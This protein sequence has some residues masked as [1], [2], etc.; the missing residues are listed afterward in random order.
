MIS[1]YFI[2][3]L[4]E[5]PTY[6]SRTWFQQDEATFHTAN[7]TMDEIHEQFPQKCIFR[8]GDITWPPRSPDLILI[9]FFVV[10]LKS[11]VY[12][13]Y[14]RISA[15]SREKTRREVRVIEPAMLSSGMMQNTMDR[16]PE[17][18]VRNGRHLKDVI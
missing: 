12:L 5:N 14:I 16:F 10:Y 18:V 7:A 4:R 13:N 17:C 11:R 15:E 3:Q 1:S 2:P 6:S 9:Y 8:F